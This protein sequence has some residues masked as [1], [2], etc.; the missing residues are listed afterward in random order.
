MLGRSVWSLRYTI[1]GVHLLI[2]LQVVV[3]MLRGRIWTIRRFQPGAQEHILWKAR[4]HLLDLGH[5]TILSSLL[6]RAAAITVAFSQRPTIRNNARYWDHAVAANR[7]LG[8]RGIPISST[9]SQRYSQ[10]H[11]LGQYLTGASHDA[12]SPVAGA[13]RICLKMTCRE[14]CSW[15]KIYEHNTK[16]SP[17]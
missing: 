1:L 3:F 4:S 7:L 14:A 5:Q 10:Q 16:P 11:H 13:H 9:T 15:P 12:S 8:D 17:G 6:R 2:D